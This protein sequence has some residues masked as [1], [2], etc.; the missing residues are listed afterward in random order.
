MITN[1]QFIKTTDDLLKS[2]HEFYN[3]PALWKAA[4]GNAPRYFVCIKYKS[5]YILGLS[6]FCAFDQISIEDYISTFRYQTDGGTTQQHITWVTKQKRV[7]ISNI[8]KGIKRAFIEWIK[9]FHGNYNTDNA[10]FIFLTDGKKRNNK[11]LISPEELINKL[12]LQAEIGTVGEEIALDLEQRR[13]VRLGV[14]NPL[15]YIDHISNKN[16]AAGFDIYS[17]SKNEIRFIE[18]KSTLS[19]SNSFFVTENEVQTLESLKDEAYIYRVCIENL[20]TRKGIVKKV[21]K[22][23]IKQLKQAGTL[24][25]VAYKVTLD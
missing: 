8:D 9:T 14:K 13:L 2:T 12:K 17:Y 24:K 4:V 6:K 11:H 10:F 15:N 25:P 7:S 1:F 21:L 20:K 5:R 18:V 19:D 3:K 23:P 22:N 16:I